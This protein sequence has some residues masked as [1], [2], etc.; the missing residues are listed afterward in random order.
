MLGKEDRQK[1][2]WENSTTSNHL[3]LRFYSCYRQQRKC[4]RPHVC[5][6][7]SNDKIRDTFI[8]C[9]KD[10]KTLGYGF[11]NSP[12]FGQNTGW[13]SWLS[14]NLDVSARIPGEHVFAT[15]APASFHSSQ[16]WWSRFLVL[17][18]HIASRSYLNIGGTTLSEGGWGI[19]WKG[20][21]SFCLFL[22]FK[23]N[24]W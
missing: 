10:F 20:T 11:H 1:A 9:M 4:L 17:G 19:H 22:S 23:R 5:V 7:R 13:H 21:S 12:C 16:P 14:A 3:N 24:F 2:W 8:S 18:E 6:L 15:A